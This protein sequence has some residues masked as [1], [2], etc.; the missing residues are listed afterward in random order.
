ME[1]TMR[2]CPYCAEEIS[3]EAIRC[4]HCRSRL[5]RLD[6]EGWYRDQPGR[7]LGGVAAALARSL[8]LPVAAVRA[9]FVLLVFVHFLGPILYLALWLTIPFRPED[10]SILDRLLAE[11]R[12]FG[13]RMWEDGSRGTPGPRSGGVR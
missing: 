1:G 5:A 9:A 3:A 10:D 11:A 13:A 8:G 2:K 12:A 7:K 4:R 6:P